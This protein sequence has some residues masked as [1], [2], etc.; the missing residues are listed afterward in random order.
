M[1]RGVLRACPRAKL[2]LMPIS[3]G[4]DGLLDALGVRRI[5]LKVRGPYGRPRKAFYG[6]FGNTAVIE[7]AQAC[8]L[9][10]LTLD[11]LDPLRA[12]TFGAGELIADALRRGARRV[13]VG[14]GGSAT[15]DGGAGLAAALG[16]RFLDARGRTLPA[17]GAAL[18]LLDRIDLSGLRP[19][20]GATVTGLCDVRNPLL[21]SLGATTVYGP[22]KGAGPREL[23]LL[24]AALTNYARVLRRDLGVDIAEVPGGGAAGGM[25]A[26]LMAFLGARIEPGADWVLRRLDA[27]RRAARAD[28]VL[29]GEGRLDRQSFFGKAPV[30]LAQLARRR[31]VPVRFLCGTIAP[32]ALPL[33][34]PWGP[35]AARALAATEADRLPAM[36]QVRSRL[37]R[38]AAELGLAM[39]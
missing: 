32:E 7:S 39:K 14:L 36:R 35:T 13:V 28:L 30:A 18:K 22:Q 26:G 19:L 9:A 15:N 37:R 21:G 31:G 34:R 29:T 23:R 38:A 33:L 16:V 5:G 27:G 11:R 20:R 17:G 1:A 4:G 6:R 25:G 3:D 12:T 24:E 10:G 2:D 8:G